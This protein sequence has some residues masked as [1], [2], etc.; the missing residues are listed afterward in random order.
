MS[1]DGP[2]FA[3]AALNILTDC[4]IV[5][6]PLPIL[7]K[8]NMSKRQRIA[9]MSVFALGGV[10]ECYSRFIF[11]CT[12]TLIFSTCIISI[13]RLVSIYAVTHTDDPTYNNGLTAL[14]SALEINTG[15]I[16]SSLPTL[17]G[18]FT[19]YWPRAFTTHHSSSAATAASEGE[20]PKGYKGRPLQG[21]RCGSI[22]GYHHWD[23]RRGSDGPELST[24]NQIKVVTVL[25]QEVEAGES[26]CN[27]S[28]TSSQQDLMELRNWEHRNS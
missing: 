3:N 28:T 8:L 13:L 20:V 22:S 6:L 19:R 27:R 17:K 24:D 18:L 10:Y 15:I 1:A 26:G 21:P 9:L 11:G 7:N 12:L 2:R 23:A 16:C 25:D 14:W 4:A 5:I